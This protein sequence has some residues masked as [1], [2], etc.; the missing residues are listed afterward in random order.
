MSYYNL[1][2][3]EQFDKFCSLEGKW[4]VKW[5][6]NNSFRNGEIIFRINENDGYVNIGYSL[7]QSR[8]NNPMDIKLYDDKIVLR[9]F[10]EK[11]SK[12]VEEKHS[13]FKLHIFNENTLLGTTLK[14]EDVIAIRIS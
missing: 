8:I 9:E 10:D 12:H 11:T 13:A 14:G 3:K 4:N 2:S 7:K 5:K 1:P 6:E